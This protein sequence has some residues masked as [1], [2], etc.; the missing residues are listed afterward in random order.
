MSY[1]FLRYA[2]LL[3][4][5]F[6][7]SACGNGGG[8]GNSL[9]TTPPVTATLKLS[10]VGTI[11]QGDSLV[12]IG[13]T[14][15]LPSGVTVKTD[16]DGA[17]ASGVLSVSSAS[18]PDAAPLPIYT[19]ATGAVPA[20]L[21]VLLTAGATSEFSIG[22]FATVTCDIASGSAPLAGD[23]ALTNFQTIGAKGAGMSGVT[24]NIAVEF[25]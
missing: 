1:Q 4:F 10:T 7:L 18:A 15:N 6:L 12:G 11:P 23:F 2:V 16:T 14:I 20:K 25:K 5:I 13:F 8:G 17:V 9:Q 3:T 19:P 21:T 24:E 22:S